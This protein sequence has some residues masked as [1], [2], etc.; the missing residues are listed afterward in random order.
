MKLR[1][2]AFATRKS[3]N[4][5]LN[6][7]LT[8]EIQHHCLLPYLWVIR[9]QR[10]VTCH[11]VDPR[12]LCARVSAPL[13][14]KGSQNLAWKFSRLTLLYHLLLQKARSCVSTPPTFLDG[15]FPS[16]II[17]SHV[18]LDLFH[19]LDSNHFKR[20]SLHQL[21]LVA[22]RNTQELYL[23]LQTNIGILHPSTVGC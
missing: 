13:A 23:L 19:T 4:T 21:R 11:Q 20:S 18:R 6:T 7:H 15:A 16:T 14:R 8:V 17:S 9:L 12:S 5:S 22:S 10:A 3:I 2:A 1:R